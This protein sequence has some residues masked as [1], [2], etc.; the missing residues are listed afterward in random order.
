M[1]L[2][3]N[4]RYFNIN[5]IIDLCGTEDCEWVFFDF[6]D[7]IVHRKC[8]PQ[9]IK[10]F[11]A[12]SIYYMLDCNIS[13]ELI[14]TIRQDA[15]FY[16]YNQNK[17]NCGEFNYFGLCN[18]IYKR[19][20]IIYDDRN[21]FLAISSNKFYELCLKE[22]V[23]LE[24]SLQYLDKETYEAI[25]YFKSKNKKLAIISDFYLSSKEI[26]CF[27]DS[28][29]LSIY[30]DKI[31]VSCDMKCNKVC[32]SIYQK[33][34]EELCTTGDKCIMIGDSY[35]FD[36]LNAQKF[37][38]TAY[39]KRWKS[40]VD[41]RYDQ[42]TVA[43]EF[44]K[45]QGVNKKGSIS[46]SNYAFA[47]YMF[48]EKL[49]INLR[50]TNTRDVYFLSREGEL[51]KKLFDIYQETMIF[52]GNILIRSHYLFVS[53]QST[54]AASLKSLNDETFNTIF[55]EYKN[56]S[57][58]AFLTSIGFTEDNIN[59]LSTMFDFDFNVSVDD[60]KS[61]YEFEKIKKEELFLKLY[62]QIRVEKNK[63][64][65][66]YFAQVGIGKEDKL[67]LVDVGWKGT[68]Q[69]NIYNIYD[70]LIYVNGYYFGV[71]G[72]CNNYVTNKK[73]G[74]MFSDNPYKTNLFE[75]WAFDKTFLERLL[76]ASHPSTINYDF[77]DGIIKPVFKS[78]ESEKACLQLIKPIQDELISKF[79]LICKTFN[80]TGYLVSDFERSFVKIHLDT[81]FNINKSNIM[82]QKTMYDNQFENF[83]YNVPVKEVNSKLFGYKNILKKIK[84]RLYLLKHIEFVSRILMHN[85][86]FLPVRVLYKIQKLSL[87]KKFD[88]KR[89]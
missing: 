31:F 89:R 5:K 21:L 10:R 62:D 67:S 74:L 20:S 11:W 88:L 76:F 9:D 12:K 28:I 65:K 60:F 26:E 29:G 78:Y 17:N 56:I 49:Y 69:D 14:Y 75:L 34:L 32:G 16:L 57:P 52:S 6:F 38:I 80:V 42:E 61:S 24:R 63:L 23:E 13:H 68:M 46:Y 77:E 83:G 30:F 7:T 19:I 18:E 45:I 8:N 2:K 50:K 81:V 71:T 82:L 72:R 55:M 4:N 36:V 48:I 84:S 43:K 40:K 64:L 25:K 87:I 47:L 44:M 15:E 35:K 58:K 73:V 3:K 85:N 37:G 51:L 59:S 66:D 39:H 41:N 54:Y 22:E 79:K 1:R 27:L 70:G 33:V 86:L 53:R